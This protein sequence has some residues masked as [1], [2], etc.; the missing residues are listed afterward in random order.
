MA[1]RAGQLE[2]RA[3]QMKHSK[4]IVNIKVVCV[5]YPETEWSKAG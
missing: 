2:L 4:L 5:F 3:A 1:M